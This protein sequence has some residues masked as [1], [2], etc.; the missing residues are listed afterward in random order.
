MARRQY[1]NLDWDKVIFALLKYKTHSAAAVALG[2]NRATVW[3]Y[4]HNPEF[5]SRWLRAQ[6]S[7]YSEARAKLEAHAD[8][9]ADVVIQIMN[10][11]KVKP[12]DRLRASGF[13]LG[14][15][16][17]GVPL[18]DVEVGDFDQDSLGL[19]PEIPMEPDLSLVEE[20]FEARRSGQSREPPDQPLSLEQR[21]ILK[22]FF[23]ELVA[24]RQSASAS[25]PKTSSAAG[26]V[27][28]AP[29]RPPRRRTLPPIRSHQRQFRSRT[30]PP[31]WRRPRSG[32][33][34]CKHPQT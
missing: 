3:R 28:T 18:D 24:R 34:N 8:Q 23:E 26:P 15:R 10:D 9:A 29:T 25:P 2:V 22:G 11:P 5:Q 20:P 27:A 32:R 14:L 7:V 31:S 1:G 19:D 33:R 16:P 17:T 21:P 6:A 13:I 30:R 12:A 4:T